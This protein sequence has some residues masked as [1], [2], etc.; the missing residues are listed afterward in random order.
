MGD[1]FGGP[2][3]HHITIDAIDDQV[4]RATV[5]RHDDRRPHGQRFT[6]DQAERFGS[7]GRT[8]T[9]ASCKCRMTSSWDAELN[10]WYFFSSLL[11]A[12][13]RPLA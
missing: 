3:R 9:S 7:D 10:H 6:D 1:G 5:L 4:R 8:S 11:S 2:D 13:L 12:W